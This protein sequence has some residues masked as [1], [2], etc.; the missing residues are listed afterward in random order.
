MSAF[1]STSSTST[2]LRLMVWMIWPMV[3][4]T[5]GRA[6]SRARPAAAASDPTSARDRS[7]PSAVAAGER[8]GTGIDRSRN[9]GKYPAHDRN[10]RGR[11][12]RRY[13]DRRRSPGFR[14]RSWWGTDGDPPAQRNAG[15]DDRVDLPANELFAA[16]AH[17]AGCHLLEAGDALHDGGLAAPFEPISVVMR[18]SAPTDGCRSPHAPGRS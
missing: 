6:R 8:H 14:A 15:R 16:E 10:R 12:Q 3:C 5:V 7:R 4:T 2:P 13:V 9:A 11:Q 1:C 18:R 17:A